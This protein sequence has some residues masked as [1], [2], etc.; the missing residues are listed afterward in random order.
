MLEVVLLEHTRNYC[1]LRGFLCDAPQFSHENHGKRFF[2]FTL[3]VPR[4]SGAVDLLP[5][6]A[7][8]ALLQ[9]RDIRAGTSVT[10]TGQ[11]RSHN[12]RNDGVRRLLIFVFAASVFFAIVFIYFSMIEL[13]KIAGIKKRQRR[14]NVTADEAKEENITL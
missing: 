6:V 12:L 1:L 14:K 13:V 11:V 5:V 9:S 3:E 7:D 4:L 2:R 8:E 10:V